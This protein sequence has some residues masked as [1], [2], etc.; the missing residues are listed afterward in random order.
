[1]RGRRRMGK[2]Y[3]THVYTMNAKWRYGVPHLL[4]KV[5]NSPSIRS[6]IRT[7]IVVGVVYCK[8]LNNIQVR[9]ETE[10]LPFKVVE[11]VQPGSS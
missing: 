8:S 11:C 10:T 2:E 3:L 5:S 4:S 7:R 1:M 6:C 9:T